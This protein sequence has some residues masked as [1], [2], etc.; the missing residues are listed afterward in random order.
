[1]LKALPPPKS[2][3][4]TA[5]AVRSTSREVVPL[6]PFA[7]YLREVSKYPVLERH[8]EQELFEKLQKQGDLE[9]AKKLVQSNL[10]LVVKIAME[11]RT[12]YSNVLDLIQEGNIGLMKAVSMYDPAKGARL[13]YYASWWIRSYI[14]KY[15]LDNF[16]LVKMGT[17]QAQRKLFY[18]LMRE[19][20]KIESMGHVAG[21]KLLS[22]N[23]G[24]SEK[25]VVEM[26]SR[27]SQSD[28]SLDAPLQPSGGSADSLLD[29]LEGNSDQRPDIRVENKEIEDILHRR[30]TEFAA[31]L[32]PRD[33]MIFKERLVAELPQTL[34]ELAKQ[35]SI[36]KERTRQLEASILTRLKTFLDDHGIDESSLPN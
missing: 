19:K 15:I 30:L 25:S 28:L 26:T 14:L 36:S 4:K 35:Y 23:L 33:R 20:E 3:G 31:S 27:L 21:P 11:Y 8:E 34:E 7:I 32:A 9:A 29:F 6:D 5:L 17:T 10:R 24:V 12:A 1:M 2:S 22:E 18:N 13:S 16:R